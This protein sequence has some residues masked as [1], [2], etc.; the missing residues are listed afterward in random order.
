MPY[1]LEFA[2]NHFFPFPKDL[3][4]N[5]PGYMTTIT[6]PE[7]LLQDSDIN[8][9]RSLVYR[10]VEDSKQSQYVAL[11]VIYFVAVLMVARYR[12]LLEHDNDLIPSGRMHGTIFLNLFIFIVNCF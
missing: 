9:L 10:E 6:N 1:K 12:D 5:I 2:Q 7:R 4:Q 11:V 8:R 3:V